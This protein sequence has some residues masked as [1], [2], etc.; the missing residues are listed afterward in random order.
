MSA[1]DKEQDGLELVAEIEERD[2][3]LDR[4]EVWLL[5]KSPQIL[6]D[7]SPAGIVDATLQEL[8]RLAVVDS[9]RVGLQTMIPV[10]ERAVAA[11]GAMLRANPELVEKIV[12]NSQAAKAAKIEEQAQGHDPTHRVWR[13]VETDNYGG[14]YPNESFHGPWLTEEAAKQVAD[15]FNNG[16]KDGSR[17]Y[18][19]KHY[20]YKLQPGFEP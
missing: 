19:V 9:V 3:A 18:T 5:A 13:V 16:S 17:W 10:V 2:D 15:I 8:N 12:A 11:F 6:T 4:L 7:K 20:T 14:D 1:G